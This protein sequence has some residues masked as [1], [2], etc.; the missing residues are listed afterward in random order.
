LV[1]FWTALAH[2][3]LLL[4]GLKAFV[5]SVIL[6]PI[7]RD[8]FRSYNVVDR[9]GQRRM[10]VYPIPRIGGIPIAVAYVAAILPLGDSG[11]GIAVPLWKFLPGAGLVFF[12]GLL[13]DF[14]TLTPLVKLAGQTAAALLVFSSGLSVGTL[15]GTNELPLYLNLPLTVFWVLLTT[16]A[17]NL[18]DGLD[19]L[20]AGIGLVATLALFGAAWFYGNPDLAYATL[21]LACALLGFLCF[22]ANPATVFLGDS[23]A[24]LIGFLLGCYGMIWTQKTS[25]L[26]SL[27]VPLIA[28]SVPLLDVT[29]AV[30]RR[31]LRRQPIFSADRS[32]IHHRLLD[33]GLTPRKAVFVLYGFAGV[34]AA[35]SLLL[36]APQL[37]P[38]RNV[39][40][41]L[42]I[43]AAGLGLRELRYKEF[44]FIG[45]LL[46]GGGLRKSLEE[47]LWLDKLRAALEAA[48]DHEAWWLTLA[49]AARDCGWSRVRWDAPDGPREILLARDVEPSWTF[50]VP[51][52]ESG[53]IEIEGGGSARGVDLARFASILRE[54][55][56]P[57]TAALPHPK[58]A[59]VEAH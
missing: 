2:N 54:G 38:F 28:L 47:S 4:A 25:T 51:L 44:D 42:L 40:L 53:S 45:R 16:N 32:H 5:V 48:Q 46:F 35:V 27:L 57:D 24:L 37:A 19:G 9:P 39:L 14:F 31:L 7:L 13:D 55:A 21:P 8:V 11:A 18:I 29:V 12:T 26:L 23:G 49:S 59:V 34:A 15:G 52:G 30:V 22:N 50:S 56:K 58:A 20:C 3:S 1:S 17:L 36:V 33:R 6:T 41:V 43:A 10:H